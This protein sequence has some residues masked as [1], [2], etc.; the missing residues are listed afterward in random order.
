M[1]VMVSRDIVPD[2]QELAGDRAVIMSRVLRTWGMAESTLAE[3]VAPR[4]EQAEADGLLTYAFLASGW[5]GIKLRLTAKAPNEDEARAVLEKEDAEVRQLLGLHVFGIDDDTM[6]SAVGVLIE[7]R[8]DTLAVAESMTGGL[9]ASRIV[10][11]PGS[12]HWFKGGVVA[13]DSEVKFDVLGVTRGPV[14]TADCAREMAIG[15]RRHLDA[16]IG[17]AVTG[18]AGPAEQEGQPVGTAFLGFSLAE[19]SWSVPPAPCGATPS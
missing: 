7:A 12:S 2:L 19:E 3:V 13:Y 16:T 1:E 15:V 8:G 6:E 11:A 10:D 9:V 14:V 18:V 4:L 5:E 17:L